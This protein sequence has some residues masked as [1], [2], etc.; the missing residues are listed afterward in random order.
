MRLSIIAVLASLL[1]SAIGFAHP[2]TVELRLV[3]AAG[4]LGAPLVPPPV[5]IE[6]CSAN[7]TAVQIVLGHEVA[8]A[9]EAATAKNVGRELAIVVDGVV[10]ATPTIRDGIHDGKVSVTLKSAESAQKL[11]KALSAK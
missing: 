8:A 2:P 4:R 10:Q 1:F 9:F 7:G 3:D 11:A 6:R 5:P